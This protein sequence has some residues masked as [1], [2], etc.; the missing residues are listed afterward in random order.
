MT[1]PRLEQI[2]VEYRSGNIDRRIFMERL[3]AVL[4]SYAL[5]HQ[6]LETSGWAMSVVSPQ[7]SKAIGV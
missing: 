5:A 7:E 3:I 4:G 1:D 6:F 2:A